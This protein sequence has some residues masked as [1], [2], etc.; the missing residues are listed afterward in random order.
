MI[1]KIYPKVPIVREGLKTIAESVR[2]PY[3]G[4]HFDP[5][6]SIAQALKKWF[7]D[8]VEKGME[9]IDFHLEVTLVNREI[10]DC[11]KDSLF[12]MQLQKEMEARGFGH[13]PVSM[14]Y[15]NEG[16][17]KRWDVVLTYVEQPI[18]TPASRGDRW[19]LYG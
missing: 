6:V 10:H 18:G 8:S 17:E 5:A 16:K 7:D 11:S 15:D 1:T 13:L 3:D 19:G 2:N 9:Q 4:K 14:R 12:R